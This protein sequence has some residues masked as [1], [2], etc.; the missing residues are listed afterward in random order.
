MHFAPIIECPHKQVIEYSPINP[1]Y[2]KCLECHK[3]ICKHPAQFTFAKKRNS[4]QEEQYQKMPYKSALFTT[5]YCKLC[6]SD[7]QPTGIYYN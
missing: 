7:F 1:Y 3:K 6:K 4:Y 2:T 5:Y